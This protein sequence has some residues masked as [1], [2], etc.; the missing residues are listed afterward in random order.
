MIR[1]LVADPETK[2]QLIRFI[3]A[4]GVVTGLAVAVYWILAAPFGVAPL[5]ANLVGYVAAV[6]SGYLLH[7]RWSFRDHGDRDDPAARGARFM[8]VS[9]ISLALN[10]LWVWV[11]T[12]PLGGPPWWPILPMLAVTPMVTFL[13]NRKWVFG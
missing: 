7:S 1:R 10:S 13:L 11:L 8:V 5:L 9:V 3:I 4:G 12:E 6:V 2:G